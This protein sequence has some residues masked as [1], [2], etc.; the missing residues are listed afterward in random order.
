MKIDRKTEMKIDGLIKK[1]TLKEKVAQLS[2]EGG[3]I[4]A[5]STVDIRR[6]GIP[7][8][9]CADGPHGVRVDKATSFPVSISTAATWDPKLMWKLAAAMGRETRAKGRDQLLAP[10]INICRDP[11]NGRT[12][13]AFGEDPFLTARMAVAYVKGLHSEGVMDCVK[14]YACNNEEKD[15]HNENLVYI[16]ERTLREIYLP[17]F[18]A[19]VQK[20]GCVSI[21]GAYNG[22][23]GK[24]CC[25]NEHLLDILKNEWGFKGFVVS[26]WGACHSTVPSINAGLDL[27]MPDG[28]YLGKDLIKAVRQGKVKMQTVDG[29]VRRVLR[30]K[31]WAGLFGKKSKPNEKLVQCKQHV[32]LARK[33]ATE[34]IVLLK[35]KNG[36]LPLDTRKLKSIAVIGHNADVAR[37]GDYGSSHVSP[38]YT[39]T[40]LAGI[41][42][43][44]GSIR[45]NYAHGCTLTG[46]TRDMM[47]RAVSVA[48]ESDVAILFIGI[49]GEMEGEGL[50]RQHLYLPADQVKLIRKIAG[51]NKKTIAVIIGGSVITM[52]GWVNRVPAVLHAWYPGLEGGYAIADV[53]FGGHNPSGKM[54]LTTPQSEKQMPGFTKVYQKEGPGY[55]WFDRRKLKPL[56][57]F[58]HGLSYTEFKYSALKIHPKK[59]FPREKVTVSLDVRNTGRRTGSEVV[60]L[61][62]R[63]LKS[64]VPRP[65]KELKGFAKVNLNPGE[66]KKVKIALDADAL[67]FYDVKRKNFVVEPGKFEVLI[68]SSSQDIRLKGRFEKVSR[69]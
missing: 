29:A 48:K 43:K 45:I 24:Y 10:C 46:G 37:L 61:Y 49:G 33:A 14:H 62:I 12:N 52:E 64:S 4:P 35:N 67:V 5:F 7:G 9:K 55:R 60:Q 34:S 36:L 13:E 63:D 51:V 20:A 66:K 21:M 53:L 6:L 27:E 42:E 15:R 47:K 57:P 38:T 28:R 41:L 23:N 17:A 68:G 44:A 32:D 58:G 1:M 31:F 56:F 40:P 22:V 30:A 18:K 8:I 25:H 2:G 11:R 3:I 39:I 26:D 59:S 65:E 50:D 19:A 16:D 54:P 69:D